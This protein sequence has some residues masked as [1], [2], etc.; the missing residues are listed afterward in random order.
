MNPS[1]DKS[2]SVI[3]LT[4]V[5]DMDLV[6]SN[7]ILEQM[8]VHFRLYDPQA[9]AK[10]PNNQH[11]QDRAE[12]TKEGQKIKQDSVSHPKPELFLRMYGQIL[13]ELQKLIELEE[14][15][16]TCLSNAVSC[17][18]L[19]IVK[20]GDVFQIV[21]YTICSSTGGDNLEQFNKCGTCPGCQ[22]CD[23]A[24]TE[25]GKTMSYIGPLYLLILSTGA[26]LKPFTE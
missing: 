19:K 26:E 2:A 15:T 25:M 14:G 11:L 21:N 5:P 9:I 13:P 23:K 6:L 20:Q 4:G 3:T 17:R 22:A 7:P 16:L 10:F 24:M 8:W 1:S 12:W 18:C